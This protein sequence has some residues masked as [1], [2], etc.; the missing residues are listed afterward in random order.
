MTPEQ[1]AGRVQ[2]VRGVAA[3]SGLE[4]I[5]LS[6]P[7]SL[8]W[9]FSARSHVP[10]TLDAACCDVV[11][12][13]G[14]AKPTVIANAIEVPRLRDTEFAGLDLDWLELPWSTDRR[15]AAAG[16]ADAGSD[17][18]LPGSTNVAADIVALR[19]V[20]DDGHI[21]IL[22][23][24]CRDTAAALTAAAPRL[25]PGMTEYQ[26]AAV[27]VEELM[28]CELDPVCVFVGAD[29]RGERHRHPLPTSARAE[30]SL[31]LV[32]CG[33][34]QGLIASA[35]RFVFFNQPAPVALDAYLRLLVVESAYLDAS[36]P[37]TPI[38]KAFD[39]GAAEYARQGFDPDEYTRHHQGGFSGFTPRDYPA[40]SAS[41][42]LLV[43]NSVVAW[44]PSAAAWKVEDTSLVT[45]TGPLPLVDDGVWPTITAG[46]RRRPAPLVLS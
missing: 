24:V 45:A 7:A 46:S 12:D 43:E 23:D 32:C 26:A 21:R 13:A 9:L 34:R 35:T 39:A 17:S 27:M 33:R 44:N 14:E 5:V 19:R 4:R 15:A 20:L 6:A 10:M 31:M 37:G 42:E 11:I 30:D 18:G 25:H 16:F 40:H 38:G 2:K 8:S 41:T 36:L 3:R 22:T 28:E 1:F 29:G